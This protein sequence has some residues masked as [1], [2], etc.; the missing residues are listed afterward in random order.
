MRACVYAVPCGD[1][2]HAKSRVMEKT[3]DETWTASVTGFSHSR[4]NMFGLLRHKKHINVK[5][6]E[7]VF[8][9]LRITFFFIF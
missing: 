9:V 7:I 3:R 6:L 4:A 1:A 8:T 2:R 5:S